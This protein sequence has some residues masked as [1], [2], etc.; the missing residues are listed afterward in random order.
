MGGIALS[1]LKFAYR[2]A[3]RRG[4]PAVTGRSTRS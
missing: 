4:N 2:L 3:R 1:H